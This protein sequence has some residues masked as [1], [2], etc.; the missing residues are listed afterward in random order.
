MNVRWSLACLLFVA[1]AWPQSV[2]AYPHTLTVAPAGPVNPGDVLTFTAHFN[3]LTAANVSAAC[4][5]EE[6]DWPAAG[7]G[8]FV[9]TPAGYDTP[10]WQTE[11]FHTTFGG[12]VVGTSHVFTTTYKVPIALGGQ[13]VV[14][15]LHGTG[16]CVP[17]PLAES[18]FASVSVTVNG[19]RRIR[20]LV[21]IS[22]LDCFPE[23]GCPLC[24]QVS[25]DKFNEVVLPGVKVRAEA[26]LFHQERLI[27]VL[28]QAGAGQRLPG[29][30]SIRLSE[31]D[32]A[33]LRRQ[34]HA[35]FTIVLAGAGILEKHRVQLKLVK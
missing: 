6:I 5:E 24:L 32:M 11:H 27:A 15:E 8:Y 29:R 2:S 22:I 30:S 25:L 10:T 14:F 9:R 4:R 3:A 20:D 17:G 23:P 34:G 7:I 21:H 12:A 1:L 33:L 35:D 28:G 26:R 19:L 31:A 16:M 13:T 18:T